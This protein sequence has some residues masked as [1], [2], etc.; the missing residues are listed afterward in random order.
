MEHYKNNLMRQYASIENYDYYLDPFYKFLNDN[1]FNMFI[2]NLIVCIIALFFFSR[3]IRT[4]KG[5]PEE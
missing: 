1:I 2:I 4:W 3:G 5:I